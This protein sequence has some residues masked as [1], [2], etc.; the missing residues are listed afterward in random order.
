[1]GD[2]E[3]WAGL[4]SANPAAL[5]LS[6]VISVFEPVCC[7]G[8]PAVTRVRLTGVDPNICASFYQDFYPPGTLGE[9]SPMCEY[10]RGPS[11]SGSG[12]VD[13]IFTQE[14]VTMKVCEQDHAS[15]FQHS[16]YLCML[17][18]WIHLWTSPSVTRRGITWLCTEVQENVC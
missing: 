8:E 18:V 2:L 14:Q 10:G 3:I 6:C 15:V 1:M 12:S 11:R 5:S 17:Y 9:V 13:E 16:P 4:T 7:S